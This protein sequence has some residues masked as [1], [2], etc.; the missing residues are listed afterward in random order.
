MIKNAIL[1]FVSFALFSAEIKFPWVVY[2]GD[3]A[4]IEVFRPYNPIVFDSASHPPLKHLLQ[5]KKE[6][7]GYINLA[8]TSEGDR[9]FELVKENDLFIDENPNW[10][11]SWAV[12]IRKPYWKKLVLN[13]IIPSILDQGFTGLF[14]DQIDVAIQLENTHKGMVDAAID[15]VKTI[16]KKFSGIRLMMN[17]AYEILP[18]VGRSID[19]ELAETLY[20]SY[21]FANKKYFVRPEEEFEWQISELNKAR[22]SF[23]HLVFFS[24]DYWDLSDTEMVE[25]I[26]SVELKAGFR[27]FV[28]T[29]SLDSVP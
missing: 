8:E 7:L 19:Y 12:D 3:Q 23:P 11:G 15:L 4:P 29:I 17:R 22:K 27:P 18:K 10:K 16:R 21:D 5:M 13:T 25:K 2:Y 28:S 26:Y 14:F 6:I 24:L 9:W 20:T 1:F